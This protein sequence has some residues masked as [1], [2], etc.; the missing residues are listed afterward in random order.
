MHTVHYI[1]AAGLAGNAK[2]ALASAAG[3]CRDSSPPTSPPAPPKTHVDPSH[4]PR[5]ARHLSG[6]SVGAGRRGCAFGPRVE[7]SELRFRQPVM[8][9]AKRWHYDCVR[10]R[11]HDRRFHDQ[12]FQEESIPLM[13]RTRQHNVTAAQWSAN[14]AALGSPD[15]TAPGQPGLRRERLLAGRPA[16]TPAQARLQGAAADARPRRGARHDAGGRRRAGDEGLGD[17]EGRHP[18][19]PLVPAADGLDRRE[20]RLLLRARRRRHGDRRVLRQA[21]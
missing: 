5:G 8:P 12:R 15:L 16:P 1:V 9:F 4:R 2:A 19:H 11:L 14:G 13:P 17:G 7:G 6:C 10:L 20:A 3:P 18:L 21:S